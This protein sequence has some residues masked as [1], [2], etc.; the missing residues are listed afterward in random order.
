MPTQAV[1]L[2]QW[3]LGRRAEALRHYEQYV[4]LLTDLAIPEDADKTLRVRLGQGHSTLANCAALG[5]DWRCAERIQPVRPNC[6][7]ARRGG[8]LL[9][10]AVDRSGLG[11]GAVGSVW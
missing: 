7:G 9:D 8:F 1:G 4:A 11:P 10:R 3:R 5:G 2:L 6:A